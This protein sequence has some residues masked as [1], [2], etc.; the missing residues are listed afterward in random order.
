MVAPSLDF[1]WTTSRVV[2]LKSFHCAAMSVRYL[3]REIGTVELTD[4]GEVVGRG[5]HCRP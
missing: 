2:S 1:H 4:L 3:R 5:A